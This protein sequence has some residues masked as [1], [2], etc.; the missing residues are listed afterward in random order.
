MV[1]YNPMLA[2]YTIKEIGYSP[3]TSDFKNSRIIVKIERIQ[4]LC[5]DVGSK[6]GEQLHSIFHCGNEVHFY[7]DSPTFKALSGHFW[8]GTE[9]GVEKL[10]K[11]LEGKV[12]A[13]TGLALEK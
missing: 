6:S 8:D 4:L 13:S 9:R 12:I 3:K 5:R 10:K 11:D 7:L 2:S 1:E